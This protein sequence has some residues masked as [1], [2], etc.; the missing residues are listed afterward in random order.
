[1][2][3]RS[4]HIVNWQERAREFDLGDTVYPFTS[5]DVYVS[6]R[7]V[8]VFD[9][10]GMVDVEYAN[11]V[12]R[13]PVE[14]LQRTD[15]DEVNPPGT[16][17]V[18]GGAGTVRVPGGP[19]R[20]AA[21]R[22]SEAFVKKALY[23]ASKDRQYKAR[24]DEIDNGSFVCPKCKEGTLR[25]AVYKRSEGKSDRLMGCPDCLFLIKRCDIIGH[26]DHTPRHHD[27]LAHLRVGGA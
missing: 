24:R 16:D 23:W 6:G 10:I 4:A 20:E 3:G 15:S 26:P 14:E 17:N 25:N 19:V 1:M 11:G 7:V 12:K 5:D 18:P 2:A 13:H 21:R 8:A 9:A 27:P 22:V